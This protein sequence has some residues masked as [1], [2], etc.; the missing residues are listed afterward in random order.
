MNQGYD[1][2]M[3]EGSLSQME[4]AAMNFAHRFIN[5]GK[6]RMNYINQ[7]KK[8]ADEYRTRI[9]SGAISAEDAAKQVQVIRNQILEAQRLRTSDLGKAKAVSLKKTGLTLSD[10][11]EKYSQNKYEKPFLNLSNLQKN[12]V[13]LEIIDSSGRPRPAVNASAQNYTKLGRGLLFVTLGI[14]VYNIA[15]ADDKAKATAREGVVIG[16]GFAG[17]AAGGA[18]AGL[19]CGPGAPVCVT[20]GVFV[21]GALGALGADV[22]FGWFFNE[23]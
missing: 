19:A 8:V 10:L 5:D 4:S 7:T 20:V 2:S 11:T 17:G 23:N 15:V 6:V 21:G 9:N 16:G 1:R 14:A 22:S 18:L 3:L 13:Y 12:Q